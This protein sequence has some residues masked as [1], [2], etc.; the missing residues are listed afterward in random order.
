MIPRWGFY[1]GIKYSPKRCLLKI[2]PQCDKLFLKYNKGYRIYCSDVCSANSRRKQKQ[3]MN[4]KIH[5]KRDKFEEAERQRILYA[6]G[7]SSKK[8]WKAG[9]IHVPKPK[10]NEDGEPDW[11]LYHKSLSSKLWKIGI[12]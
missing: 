6:K 1:N 9:I 11:E 8:R 10:L 12:K 5:D 2:C 3:V 4:K 7:L